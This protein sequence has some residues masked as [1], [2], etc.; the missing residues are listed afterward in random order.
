MRRSSATT[1]D[2]L[3]CP[4]SLP[5]V[6]TTAMATGPSSVDATAGITTPDQASTPLVV[7][8]T[9]RTT[10]TSTTQHPTPHLPTS[11]QQSRNN[12]TSPHTRLQLHRLSNTLTTF[13]SSQLLDTTQPNRLQPTATAHPGNLRMRSLQRALLPHHLSPHHNLSQ[14]RCCQATD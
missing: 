13:N 9:T 10:T 2:H 8:A 14:L 7:A 12:Y 3:H 11:H 5:F 1:P 6:P 4:V